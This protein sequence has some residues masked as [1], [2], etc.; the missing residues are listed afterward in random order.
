MTLLTIGFL[1]AATRPWPR[2]VAVIPVLWAFVA[3]SAASL[4]GV[5]ADMMLWVA[6]VALSL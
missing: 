4:L 6:G 3:G 5:R 2:P 1:F